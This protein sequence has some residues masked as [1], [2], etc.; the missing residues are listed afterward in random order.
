ML[1]AAASHSSHRGVHTPLRTSLLISCTF[2][3]AKKPTVRMMTTGCKST[4]SRKERAKQTT[5]KPERNSHKQHKQHRHQHLQELWWNGTRVKDCWRPEGIQTKARTTR[6]KKG[7]GK[8]LDVQTSAPSETASIVSYP[9]QDPSVI[10]ELSCISSV[11]PWI[12]GV[13]INSMSSTQR[14][15]GAEYVLHSFTH[16]RSSIQDNGYRCLIL[17]STLQ[18]EHDS[19]ATDDDQ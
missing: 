1:V 15:A 7:E 11:I 5:H 2:S 9:S 18:V 16:V 4:L 19:N 8:H 17:E 12:V 14:D 6:K 10:G 13:T 3:G